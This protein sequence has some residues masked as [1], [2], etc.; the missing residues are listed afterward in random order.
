MSSKSCK[1]ALLY[2]VNALRTL[3][4]PLR[5]GERWHIAPG[6]ALSWQ[7]W[8]SSTQQDQTEDSGETR[9]PGLF[10][11]FT[12]PPPSISPACVKC[13]AVQMISCLAI[14]VLLHMRRSVWV[15]VFSS[16]K[17][18]QH[19]LHYIVIFCTVKI[20][21]WTDLWGSAPSAWPR[22]PEGRWIWRWR[23]RTGR[24]A[25][26]GT[27]ATADGA[28]LP[29]ECPLRWPACWSSPSWWTSWATSSSSCPCAGTRSSGM[30]VRREGTTQVLNV[31][32]CLFGDK[33]GGE[34]KDL[35][36]KM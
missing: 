33:I 7:I 20:L 2:S 29:A 6:R 18:F 19:F 34:K 32:R 31:K 3:A 16:L 12:N 23:M 11:H 30:Q 14:R 21:F 8:S 35:I 15:C 13:V 10:H 25:R 9:A 27:R 17:K 4:F 5:T 22:R 28:P 1:G 26:R 24:T 36:V